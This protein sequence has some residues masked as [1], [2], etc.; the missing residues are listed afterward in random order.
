MQVDINYARWAGEIVPSQTAS[1]N[2]IRETG[3]GET[4]TKKKTVEVFFSRENR[5]YTGD[6]VSQ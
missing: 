3:W 6:P 2:Q 1:A 4:K 5:D